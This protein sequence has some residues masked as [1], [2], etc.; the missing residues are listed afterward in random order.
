MSTHAAKGSVDCRQLQLPADVDAVASASAWVR[1][2][3]QEW[4][5]EAD[6]IHRVDLCVSE[7][8]T[9]IVS[10]GFARADSGRRVELSMECAGETLRVRIGDDGVPFNLLE[11]PP[12]VP[13]SSLAAAR[14]GGL[15]IHLVRSFADRIG[16]VRQGHRN[17]TTLSFGL[18]ALPPAGQAHRPRGAER[19]RARSQTARDNDAERRSGEDRRRYAFIADF[20]I[21]EG[22]DPA[23][24]EPV[25]SRCAISDL[26]DGEV[27]LRPGEQ[28]QYVA[29]VISGRLR[30]HF[31]SPESSDFIEVLAGD[32]VGEMSVIDGSPVSAFVVS[33][34]NCR[35]LLVP[36]EVFVQQFL[37][38]PRVARN[39]IGMLA[40]RMRRN[41]R[42]II[43]RYEASLKLER[44]EQELEAAR[45]I[46]AG[47]LPPGHALL[48]GVPELQCAAR[49]RSARDVGGDLYDA[50]FVDADH[51]VIAVGDVCGKGMPA[52]LFMVK[53]VTLLRGEAVQRAGGS[54]LS[55][56]ALVERVNTGLYLSMQGRAFVTLFC[57]IYELSTGRL[58][59]VNAGHNPPLLIQPD[60]PPVSLA[61]PRN[62][63]CGVKECL[64]Y[65]SGEVVLEPGATLLLYTD[66]V[67][68]AC[69]PSGQMFGEERLRE[70]LAGTSTSDAPDVLAGLFEEV[71][72]FTA[73]NGDHDDVTALVLARRPQPSE[74]SGR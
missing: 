5:V 1:V 44:L 7:L 62:L 2:V 55:A 72:R 11:H 23:A 18:P 49:M 14:I 36:G 45:E 34:R 12:H 3:C 26:T 47:M 20:P 51:V 48:A 71:D 6:L 4:L 22:V 41:N 9:N 50:F 70:F 60:A 31:E 13:P 57:A 24:L 10:H 54:A 74:R 27:L 25:M 64:S 16:Y 30:V 43:D 52:A 73:G 59:Y 21:F 58:A 42:I 61:Q 29:F 28:N 65:R 15:G 40:N 56:S 8:L 69:S 67:T 32:C 19:R 46:Q 37:I 35:A 53:S 66:G 33:D 68:E 39:V 17:V 63:V 38:I